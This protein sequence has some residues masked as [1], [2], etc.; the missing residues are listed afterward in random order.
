MPA[1]AYCGLLIESGVALPELDAVDAAQADIHFAV[2]DQPLAIPSRAPIHDYE[3]P[4]GQVW[5]SIFR[6]DAGYVLR[7]PKLATFL[8]SRDVHRVCCSPH[9]GTPPET[10]RHLFLDQVMPLVVASHGRAVLHASAVTVAGAA[11]AFLGPSGKG[12]STLA[13]SSLNAGCMLLADDCLPLTETAGTF[14]AVPSYPGLRLWPDV[15]P[16]VAGD[17]EPLS[18]VCHYSLKARMGAANAGVPFHSRPLPLRRVYVLGEPTPDIAIAP[19]S[20]LDAVI[21]LVKASYMLD[22]TDRQA[23]TLQFETLSRLASLSLCFRLS[24]PRDLDRLADVHAAIA[25]H[26]NRS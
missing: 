13:A 25:R 20:P 18:P 16:T 12:K 22:I 17:C 7:F 1:S 2:T 21:E 3:S 11:V 4:D 23:L 9:A 14:I 6:A 15:V 19:L 24:Y 5:M 8:V 26:V 10:I